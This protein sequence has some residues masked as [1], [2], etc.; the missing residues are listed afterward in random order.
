MN[1]FGLCFHHLGLAVRKPQPARVF[2]EGLGYRL[3]ETVFDPLQNVYLSL[4]RHE[5]EPAVELVFPGENWSPVDGMFDR[6]GSG[7]VYHSCY[8]TDDIGQTI[9]ALENQRLRPVCKSPAKPAILFGGALVSFYQ[10]VGI[11][12]I[13]IVEGPLAAEPA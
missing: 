10:I 8:V 4:C 1:A 6:Y 9:A 13:E 7:L 2:L 3:G 11:G 12:L 5:V